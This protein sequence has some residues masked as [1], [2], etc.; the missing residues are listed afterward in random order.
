MQQMF[1]CHSQQSGKGEVGI[2]DQ[3]LRIQTYD[4][5]Y[6][7]FQYE[8]KQVRTLVVNGEPMFV[9]KDVRL[10]YTH[11][12]YNFKFQVANILYVVFWDR[13]QIHYKTLSINM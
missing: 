7:I 10:F 4:V 11:L 12:V 6:R 2:H 8:G 5:V 9:A 3:T 13:C 1:F